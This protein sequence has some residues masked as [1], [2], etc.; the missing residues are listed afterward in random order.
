MYRYSFNFISVCIV[1][2]L[3]YFQF[4]HFSTCYVSGFFH[5]A[6]NFFSFLLLVSFYSYCFRCVVL[7]LFIPCLVSCIVS[8]VSYRSYLYPSESVLS[9]LVSCIVS[10]PLFLSD[11]CGD[12]LCFLFLF[13]PCLGCSVPAKLLVRLFFPRCVV[14]VIACAFWKAPSLQRL[15]SYICVAQRFP[16]L[17]V[18]YVNVVTHAVQLHYI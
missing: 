16:V 7:I 5:L 12:G 17:M 4:V 14:H 2:M 1:S 3:L 9:F 11:T 13:F 18:V 8:R 6:Y 15:Q 10:V